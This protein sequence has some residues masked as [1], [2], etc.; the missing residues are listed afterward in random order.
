M[1]LRGEGFPDN[2]VII[3]EPPCQGHLQ[4]SGYPDIDLKAVSKSA[5]TKKKN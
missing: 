2:Y 3:Q 4:H 1:R 5:T